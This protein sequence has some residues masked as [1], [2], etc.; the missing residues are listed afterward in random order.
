[1]TEQHFSGNKSM[2]EYFEHQNTIQMLG[3]VFL[4]LAL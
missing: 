4:G 3:V 1:M 2:C